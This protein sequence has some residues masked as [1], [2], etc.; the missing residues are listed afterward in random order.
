MHPSGCSSAP[1]LPQT[2]IFSPP[3]CLTS[4]KYQLLSYIR[5]NVVD[6]LS[7]DDLGDVGDAGDDII[8]CWL[9]MIP[10]ERG[11]PLMVRLHI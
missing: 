8:G 11:V 2:C 4:H 10:S 7:D 5:I 6:I 9:G 1:D 3:S